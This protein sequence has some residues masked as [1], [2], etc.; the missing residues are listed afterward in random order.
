MKRGD[1][2]PTKNSSNKAQSTLMNY[3]FNGS[4]E[5]ILYTVPNY[6][7][8]LDINN[9]YNT[10]K[11]IKIHNKVIKILVDSE[12]HLLLIIDENLNIQTIYFKKK[13]HQKAK[14]HFVRMAYFLN[15]QQKWKKHH[16][17][18]APTTNQMCYLSKYYKI[19]IMNKGDNHHVFDFFVYDI[20]TSTLALV[21][22][23]FDS[24]FEHK[25]FYCTELIYC[26]PLNKVLLFYMDQMW[27]IDL[28][29]CNL[30]QNKNKWK[31]NIWQSIVSPVFK[32][33]IKSLIYGYI[34][35][36]FDYDK[37]TRCNIYCIDLRNNELYQSDFKFYVYKSAW[38]HV[39]PFYDQ[40]WDGYEYNHG[41]R[42]Y[43]K[44]KRLWEP[45]HKEYAAFV[46]TKDCIHLSSNRCKHRVEKLD[47]MELLPIELITG[48]DVLLVNGYIRICLS[49]INANFPDGLVYVV[50]QFH[51]IHA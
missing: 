9:N 35:I 16:H 48:F 40:Y 45:R 14:Q 28:N 50:Q 3:Y 38:N 12:R 26:R 20:K 31:L 11:S 29:D 6:I 19:L 2:D 23:K 42:A 10:H 32:S 41:K 7:H 36:C 44:L 39:I 13:H 34:L 1:N 43:N 47:I 37:T 46:A 4:N 18:L 15:F 22:S 21:E 30:K 8:F 33:Y 27:Y 17:Q 24:K 49:K 25:T 51:A 5:Y